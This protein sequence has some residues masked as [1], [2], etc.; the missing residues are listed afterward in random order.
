[1]KDYSKF[2]V[3][4]PYDEKFLFEMNKLFI[5]YDLDECKKS[6]KLADEFLVKIESVIYSYA[7]VVSTNGFPKNNPFLEFYK[8]GD[9]TEI[10][11]ALF[12]EVFKNLSINCVPYGKKAKFETYAFEKYFHFLDTGKFVNFVEDKEL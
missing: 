3:G 9:T 4:T 1:M 12:E 6:Q 2:T 5:S 10:K 8:D 11:D 7:N